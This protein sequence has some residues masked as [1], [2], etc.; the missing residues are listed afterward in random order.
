MTGEELVLDDPELF[1]V[2]EA[3]IFALFYI[4]AGEERDVGKPEILVLRK[5]LH[6]NDIWPAGVIDESGNVCVPVGVDAKGLPISVV[7][8]KEV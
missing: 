2:V 4:S 6:G 1:A 8:V 3:E 7:Q 5:H